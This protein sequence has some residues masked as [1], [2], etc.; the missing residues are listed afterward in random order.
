STKMMMMKDPD[1]E[2]GGF[3]KKS[4]EAQDEEEDICPTC[5]DDYDADNPKMVAK[6]GHH[7]HLVCILEWMERSP[8]CAVCDQVLFSY[9]YYTL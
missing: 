8:T 4:N 5:L 7:F 6:C 2:K 9:H 1:D 3:E